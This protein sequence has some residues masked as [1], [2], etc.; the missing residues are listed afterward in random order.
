M[1]I[2]L[3]RCVLAVGLVLLSSAILP[4]LGQGSRKNPSENSGNTTK[5]RATTTATVKSCVR[6]EAVLLS[7]PLASALFGGFVGENYAVVKTTVSNRC[8]NQQFILHDIYFDYSNW[9]LSGTFPGL[10]VA[11]K[12]QSK[13]QSNDVGK[14]PPAGN[15]GDDKQGDP[16]EPRTTTPAPAPASGEAPDA[17]T[18]LDDET[19]STRPG[20]VA[21]VGALDVQDQDAADAI[22]SPRNSVVKAVTLLGQVASG[23][24]FLW[25]GDV[26]KGIGAYNTG[27]AENLATLWPDRRI[28]QEKN[29][30]S[31]GYRT[32]RTTAV[33]KD[34]HGSYYAFFPLKVFLSPTLAKIFLD[35]PAVFL[36]S[37]QV[38]LNEWL[39]PKKSTGKKV[40]RKYKDTI[41]D[42]LVDLC[43]KVDEQATMLYLSTAPPICLRCQTTPPDPDAHKKAQVE[44]LL[45]DLSMPCPGDNCPLDSAV[46]KDGNAKNPYQNYLY[47]RILFE[48]YL[49]KGA[50]LHSVKIVVRGVMT[51][52]LDTVPP[53]IE[54][55]AFDNEK[56][57][58]ALWSVSEAPAAKPAAGAVKPGAAKPAA[59]GAAAAATPA[60]T[61]A[62]A[63]CT[64]TDSPKTLTGTITGKFLSGGTPSIEALALSPDAKVTDDLKCYIGS[65][66]ADPLKSSDT[67]LPFSMQLANSLPAGSKLSFVVA[68]NVGSTGETD[69]SSDGSKK[70]SSTKYDYTVQYDGPQITEVAITD[71]TA[72]ATWKPEAKLTGT[73]TGTNLAGGT[74]VV[75][76][77]LGGD[78]L[79]DVTDY[80]GTPTT[81]Q[82][83]ATKLTFALQL[84]KT[85]IPGSSKLTFVVNTKSTSG[86]TASSNE[87]Q[88][89]VPADAPKAAAAKASSPP[90]KKTPKKN[91]PN[92]GGAEKM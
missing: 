38:L 78:V 85:Q 10:N 6:A 84:T 28:D 62:S 64:P 15:G 33:A 8:D 54:G 32:D 50:S 27:F 46:D 12:R 25:S 57:G 90:A 37:P 71:G 74:V 81:T 14:K 49:V 42:M 41:V 91:T 53:I 47:H 17:S 56:T 43:D 69:G 2:R 22:W 63:K 1:R 58:A 70:L 44:Q 79:E 51:V 87:Y 48:K 52:T 18:E 9:S 68:R 86:K 5:L 72:G 77:V 30:L 89:S 55:I 19:A 67:S 23:Y 11:V 65:V 61:G 92:K 36:S 75:K 7:K 24:A 34:D 88:Y 73:V 35:S 16:P 76:S 3:S 45:V 29:I 39:D 26:S 13:T 4:A 83:S 31:L 21:T 60:K 40:S 80:I 66:T 59:G 20:E 82:D